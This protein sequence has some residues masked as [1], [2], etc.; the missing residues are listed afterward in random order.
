MIRPSRRALLVGACTMLASTVVS[1]V[2]DPRIRRYSGQRSTAIPGELPELVSRLHLVAAR[3]TVVDHPWAS[4]LATLFTI[5]ATVIARSNPLGGVQADPTPRPGLDRVA[6]PD[7]ETSATWD[8]VVS[9]CT[10]I[11]PLT[12]FLARDAGTSMGLLYGST[13]LVAQVVSGNDL[14]ALPPPVVGNTVPI[15]LS[16]DLATDSAGILL[17]RQDELI[18][19]LEAVLGHL[20]DPARR[21]LVAGWLGQAHK[22]RDE[23]IVDLSTTGITLSASA[24]DQELAF[25][26]SAASTHDQQIGAREAAIMA[27][28]LRFHAANPSLLPEHHHLAGVH[29]VR[30]MERGIPLTTWP[31]WV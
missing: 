10:E 1:C 4:E 17:A 19:V 20:T 15:T 29:A 18:F 22:D 8:Q 5:H 25:D 26:P 31:G 12:R 9:D 24:P 7:E 30:A 21:D 16:G 27:A 13:G 3:S 6:T 2:P 14:T 11:V 28:W 23:M